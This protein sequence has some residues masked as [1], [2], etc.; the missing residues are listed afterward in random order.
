MT[1]LHALPACRSLVAAA[2]SA[3]LIMSAGV[4]AAPA[5]SA[6]QPQWDGTSQRLPAALRERMIGV[7]WHRGCPVALGE[8]RLLRMPYRG[9][10]GEVHRGSLVVRDSQ[11][12][13]VLNIFRRMYEAR[14]PIRRMRLIEAYD[15]SDARSMRANNTSAFNCRKVSRH[16]PLVGALLWSRDRHQSGPEP[17][18]EG[19]DGR[20][21]GGRGVPRPV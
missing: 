4:D 11:A 13:K 5:H 20:A 16:R 6:E 21:R 2:V 18:R 8:L 10:D 14:F 15:G 1:A 12:A 19:V 17:V 9:F 7:S 3:L